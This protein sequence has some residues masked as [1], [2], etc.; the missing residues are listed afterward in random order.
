MGSKEAKKQR[1]LQQALYEAARPTAEEMRYSQ[2]A[3]AQRTEDLAGKA[4]ARPE[5]IARMRRT[6]YETGQAYGGAES[7]MARSLARRGV[8]GGTAAKAIGRLAGE[9]ASKMEDIALSEREAALDRGE[10]RR[11]AAMGAA[12]TPSSLNRQALGYME[13]PDYSGAQAYQQAGIEGIGEG[14]AGMFS[15]PVKRT[16][17]GEEEYGTSPAATGW[18]ALR[19]W[20]R[21][22]RTA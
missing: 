21:R 9:K 12:Q 3:L 2:L 13:Q 17:T 10:R 7:S 18:N 5:D 15:R 16:A 8:S 6:M 4:I 19:G 14:L 11:A 1:Q 20:L 22:R